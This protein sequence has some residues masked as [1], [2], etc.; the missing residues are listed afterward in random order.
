MLKWTYIF[1]FYNSMYL[2]YILQYYS[3]F[4]DPSRG[5][6]EIVMLKWTYFHF[7][8]S[9]TNLL[10]YSNFIGNSVKLCVYDHMIFHFYR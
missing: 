1:I 4:I 7:F 10:Q 9:L 8:I 3:G 2:R 6:K 5:K